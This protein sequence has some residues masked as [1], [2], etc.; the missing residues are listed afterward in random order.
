MQ[1]KRLSKAEA[2]RL[3]DALAQGGGAAALLRH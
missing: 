2:M 1:H 3:G